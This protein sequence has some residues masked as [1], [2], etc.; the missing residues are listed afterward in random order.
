MFRKAKTYSI[1]GDGQIQVSY[2]YSFVQKKHKATNQPKKYPTKT[3]HN[4]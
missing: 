3:R 4:Y 2:S 1:F